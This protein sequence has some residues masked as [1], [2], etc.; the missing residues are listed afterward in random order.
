MGL[1]QPST[2]A[3]LNQIRLGNA[4][5]PPTIALTGLGI[6]SLRKWWHRSSSLNRQNF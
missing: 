6:L 5:V 1:P 2:A 4:K 3:A